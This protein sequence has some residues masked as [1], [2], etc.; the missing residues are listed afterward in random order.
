MNTHSK[1][2]FYFAA[3][4]K[5]KFLRNLWKILNIIFVIFPKSQDAAYTSPLD[6]SKIQILYWNMTFSDIP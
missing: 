1:R 3:K 5:N 6:F 2:F 4:R